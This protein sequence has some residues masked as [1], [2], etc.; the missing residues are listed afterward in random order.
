MQVWTA[1]GVWQQIPAVLLRGQVHTPHQEL[2]DGVRIEIL[3]LCRV[4]EGRLKQAGV[5]VAAWLHGDDH[6]LLQLPVHKPISGGARPTYQLMS[7]SW[8]FVACFQCHCLCNS[9]GS[10]HRAGDLAGPNAFEPGADQGAQQVGT[11]QIPLPGSPQRLQAWLIAALWQPW[12]VA[13][14]IMRIK[15]QQ[16]PQA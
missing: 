11:G 8:A 9:A 15:P 2:G 16:V 3:G 13:S 7:S 14:H 5:E 10:L 4:F 1:A 6:V 12:Q